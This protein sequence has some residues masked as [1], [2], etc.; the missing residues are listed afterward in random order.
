MEVRAAI[1]LTPSTF[2]EARLSIRVETLCTI[3]SF[4]A[5]I[6]TLNINSAVGRLFDSNFMGEK[7]ILLKTRTYFRKVIRNKLQIANQ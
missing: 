5:D 6:I 1:I 2:K 7:N 3:P 4:F